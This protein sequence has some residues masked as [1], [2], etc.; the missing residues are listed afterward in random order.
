MSG[1]ARRSGAARRAGLARRAT[2]LAVHLARRGG[3]LPSGTPDRLA[4]D[5]KVL[6]GRFEQTVMVYFPDTR[7][8]LYQLRQWYG[9]LI[10]L[11]ERHP[12]VVVLQDSR[13][14]RLVR[15][16]LGLPAVVIGHYGRLDE[17]LSRS[18]VKLAL[19]VN[20]SP[21][22]FSALRFT[23]LVHVFLNHGESDKGVSVS[24]QS[25]AYDFCFVA[26]RAAVDRIAAHTMLYDAAARCVSIGRPQLDFDAAPSPP[27]ARSG[28]RRTVLYA[29]TWEGAQPSLA[30]GSVASHGLRLVRELLADGRF[31]VL[32]RPHPLN[33]LLRGDYGDA[34]ARIRRL[35]DEAASSDPAAGHRVEAQGSLADSF[36]AADLLV[37]DV[38]AVATDWLPCGR[39]LVVTLPAEREV[40]T[41]R[42]RLLDVVP[43]LEVGDLGRAADL[44]AEHAE[45]DPGREQRLALVDYYL[46]DTTPGVATR[47]FLDACSWAIELRD[48][49]WARAVATGA[50][51]P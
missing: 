36:A 10:A 49:E 29:P 18:D 32:Y 33:G 22:N 17:L 40:S 47:R 1:S 28:E 14:A 8:N 23:S 42:T 3:L 24:N 31:R 30:Y 15:A 34:D 45:R 19:Y 12:V 25:K 35:V 13:T 20:H 50:V 6:H 27:P 44:L 38:S 41:A 26:G 11:N 2:G 46:G 7:H 21:Q 39:P 9:P 16:E 37:C 4:D 48:R 51:G 5:E 43:R